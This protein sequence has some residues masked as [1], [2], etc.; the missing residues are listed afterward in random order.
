MSNQVR[1]VIRLTVG[2][3]WV[4]LI[5]CSSL[6][7]R[8]EELESARIEVNT[9]DSDPRVNE[10]ASSQLQEAKELLQAADE[11]YKDGE[12]LAVIEHRAYLARREAEVG[13][14][15][16]EGLELRDEIEQSK[17]EENRVLMQARAT[18]ADIA[19]RRAAASE[20]EAERLAAEAERLKEQIEQLE[21][22][23][24][25][26]GLVLTIG[27]VLFETDKAELLPGAQATIDRLAT[28][29]L[30]YPDRRV[31]VEGHTDSR[32]SGEYN[33]SLSE[34]RADAV[35]FALV[36]RGIDIDRVRAIGL[37]ESYPVAG[38]DS[39]AG[40]QQNRRVEIVI[41]DESGGFPASA[42]RAG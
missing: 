9:L 36:K 39:A 35:R 29:M 26:R 11:A 37:G 28:F 33:L 4:A 18:E 22:K 6:P 17:A 12:D 1:N 19:K 15:L 24:T 42:R 31:L 7:D 21:A 20:S 3:A 27:D 40:R 14:E 2:G 10:A 13:H 8:V 23:E 32:G 30:E 41:S 38:N 25:E 34:R 16:I 5:G